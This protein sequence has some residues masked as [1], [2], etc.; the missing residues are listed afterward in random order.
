MDVNNAK[1]LLFEVKDILDDLGVKF[2]LY[3]GTFLGAI[4]DSGFVAIDKDI[5][6]GILYEDFLPMQEYIIKA[7]D[8][9]MDLHVADHRHERP[10]D[11]STFGLAVKKYGEKL[12]IPI[13]SKKGNYRYNVGHRYDAVLVHKAENIEQLKEIEFYNKTFLAPA[14]YD[15]F[16]TEKYGDWRIPH[17]EFYN[18]SK[19][20]K[21]SKN[22][23][24]FWWV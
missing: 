10:H 21:E 13:W 22:G 8:S 23:D 24:D 6:I 3:G 19:C 16:L 7:L 9:C 14:R 11:G 5:D 20:K 4:R 15:E 18:V 1:K 2:F 17:K 12:D